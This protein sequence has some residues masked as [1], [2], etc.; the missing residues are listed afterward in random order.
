MRVRNQAAAT[1][2]MIG[3][4]WRVGE[5]DLSHR[6]VAWGIVLPRRERAEDLLS[7]MERETISRGLSDGTSIRAMARALQRAPSTVSR[8]M[9]RNGGAARYRAL[10]R[11]LLAWRRQTADIGPPGAAAPAVDGSG[12][13][14]ARQLSTNEDQP[15][16][17]ATRVERQSRYVHL[18]RVHGKDTTPAFVALIREVQRL[19][20]GLMASLTWDR[21]T[22]M[23]HHGR[24]TVA[25]DV[26]VYFCAQKSPWQLGTNENTNGLLRQYFPDGTD[27]SVISQ[28]A[29]DA[30]ALHLNTRPW[31][32][33]DF[34][35]RAVKSAEGV[36]LTRVFTDP[37]F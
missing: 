4:A 23:A 17:H 31:K 29:L 5:P 14:V 7:P 36:A 13:E 9:T 10:E 1:F 34:R 32:T 8:E 21:G 16:A 24:F 26:A 28:A 35:T 37:A 15:V 18:V 11:D 25:T 27:L 30:V 20:L 22:E 6:L 2:A 12:Y 3:R 19:L 33:L